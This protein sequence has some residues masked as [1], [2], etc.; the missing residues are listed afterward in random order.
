MSGGPLDSAQ[1]AVELSETQ[2]V[3]I[4]LHDAWGLARPMDQLWTCVAGGRHEVLPCIAA[5]TAWTHVL[6]AWMDLRDSEHPALL[7]EFRRCQRELLAANASLRGWID[8]RTA[9]ADYRE[10]RS[11]LGQFAD[12]FFG[13][14]GRQALR[15]LV[16]RLGG[17]PDAVFDASGQHGFQ[18][19]E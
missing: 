13:Y 4:C 8:A 11:A 6:T 15:R 3:V 1:L 19:L 16:D 17:G 2:L 14:F 18:H 9:A 10:N 7:A 12:G 5:A